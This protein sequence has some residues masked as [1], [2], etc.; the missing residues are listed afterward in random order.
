[1]GVPQNGWFIME[2]HTEIDDLGGYPILGKL[3]IERER[4]SNP[5]NDTV[6]VCNFSLCQYMNLPS[7]I[8]AGVAID[9]KYVCYWVCLCFTCLSCCMC[10]FIICII[11][12]LY[13]YILYIYYIYIYYIYIY[14]LCIYIMY[15]YIICIITYI[16]III[17]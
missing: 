14:I 4:E 9:I 7:S 12:I 8:F 17:Y 15:I 10:I 6:D 5:K 1:M 11:Y 3:H 2:N 16:Y 13:I